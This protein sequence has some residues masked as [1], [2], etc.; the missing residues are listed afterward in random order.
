MVKRTR[1]SSQLNSV[2]KRRRGLSPSFSWNS[3]WKARPT[4]LR[5][6][7]AIDLQLFA[8]NDE[9]TEKATPKKRQDLRKKG[10]VMQSRELPANLILLA[11]FISMK[12]LGNFIY[13]ECKTVFQF[14]VSGASSYD[15][16]SSSEIMRLAT[17]AVLEIAKMSAPFFVIAMIMGALGSYVQI[18]F[19]FT[20]EPLKPKF[21]NLNPLK[22]LKRIFSTRS[23]FELIKSIAKVILIFMVAWKSIQAEFTNMMK[24]MDMDIGPIT[25]YILN[26]ALDIA[27]K[28]CFSMLAISAV[29]YFFQRL[30]HEKDIRMTKQEIKEEYKQMEGNPEIKSKI[31]QK[32]R[33]ISMRRMLQEVPKADVVITNPTHLAIAIKYEPQKKSA[34]YVV[35]KGADFMA[36]RIKEVAKE[37]Q[38]YT[39]ENKPLAQ[40]LYKTV[41][42]GDAVPPE[43]YKAVA[44]VLAFVY[45]LEGKNPN[46]Q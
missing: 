24:L 17:F 22:G 36:Q 45:K 20:A 27:I 38:I 4:Y 40:A 43:L 42:V 16:S 21:S 10:Q 8:D 9:K 34:P 28:I 15:L 30:R 26:T 29:D 6:L 1:A 11:I 35:A 14:F 19:L 32:Q 33:E 44:E 23:L 12:A 37:N 41:D 25:V 31:K 3:F 2:P 46:E 13:Q 5:G 39:M 7:H 18:G